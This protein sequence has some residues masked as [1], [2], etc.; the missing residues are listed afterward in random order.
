VRTKKALP[1]FDLESPNPCWKSDKVELMLGGEGSDPLYRWRVNVAPFGL[2]S[3]WSRTVFR[4]PQGSR[5]VGRWYPE[6]IAPN[7][8]FLRLVTHRWKS[9]PLRTLRW[10]I[11]RRFLRFFVFRLRIYK[12]QLF[13]LTCFASP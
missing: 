9:I 13:S 3:S 1:S 12:I 2:L 8:A 6:C 7:L 4:S 5:L 10:W 11:L